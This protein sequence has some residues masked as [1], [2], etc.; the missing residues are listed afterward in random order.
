[1][2]SH[3]MAKFKHFLLCFTLSLLGIL[4]ISTP[5]PG[6]SEDPR[7]LV[8]PDVN[9]IEDYR[10]LPASTALV[11]ALTDAA[12]YVQRWTYSR[13]A[14]TWRERRPQVERALLKAIGLE[15]LPERT[16]LNPRIIAS[17]DLGDYVLENWIFYSR[18][19]LPVTANL[20]RPKGSNAARHPAVVCP[21]G[22]YLDGGKANL[23]YQIL[24][25]K[26]AKLGF[27]VLIYDAIGHGERLISGNTH[28]EAGFALLPLGQT[29]A[30]WMVWESMRA[31]DFLSTLPEV[32][33]SRIGVTGNSGGGLNTL[34]TAALDERVRA[35]AIAGYV[36]HFN[37]WIKYAGSHCTCCYLPGLYRSM[38][39]FEVASLTA[40]RAL[41]MLQGER[42][43][44]FAIVGARKA[45]RE[46]EAV[47]SLLGHKGS[48]RFDE[49]SGQHHAYSQPFRERIYG[50]MLLHLIGQGDG[51][52]TP[53]GSI[54]PLPENDE[55]LLCDKSGTLMANSPSVVALARRQA[56]Q[57]ISD[58]SSAD[59]RTVREA[60]RGFI[61][62]LTQPPDPE[63]HYLMPLSME[64]G[65]SS[66]GIPEKVFFLSEDGQHVPGLLWLPLHHQAPHPTLII[67]NDKGKTAVAES[68]M[69]EPLLDG[70]FAVLSVDLRGRGETLGRS[71][72]RFDNNFHLAAHSVMWGRPIAG[73]R[74]LD[75]KRTVDF[76][77]SRQ[78]LSL[79][80][81]TV[82][83]IGDE[84]LTALLAAADDPRI[85]AVACAGYYNSFLAQIVAAKVTSRA[86]LVRVWNS[87][88]MNW[89]RLDTGNFKAD[90]GSV[91]PSVL[92]TADVP[93]IA[94]LVFPRKLLYCQVRD[95]KGA[96][97]AKYQ[98][99][100][101]QILAST[102]PN[103]HDWASYYPDKSLDAGLLL[104]WLTSP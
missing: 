58:L 34:F 51:K 18:P 36:F 80:D 100:F 29:I 52:P 95:N 1:L 55:R 83:G 47:Y 81:L 99:R 94:S 50:W 27:F 5:A 93:E 57:A 76:V 10:V 48:A 19:D 61:A 49:I 64:K 97:S 75:L 54:Q 71:G 42:D 79:K 87:S 15:K 86:E 43:D 35:A 4:C 102:S 85:K 101:K 17:H 74:A 26:L 91:I 20:Y 32:D 6:A 33:S 44:M 90:L 53:E 12:E 38:E 72:T 63:P 89:G 13:D 16:P 14:N 104:K 66:D 82:V 67:V 98:T 59:L 84:G 41:L 30:G 31:I 77:E 88:A 78:D 28:H 8:T 62:Q 23:E 46:T 39:W 92:L 68:G 21:L 60:A 96:D 9:A 69:V 24:A 3:I 103:G 37:H 70:G 45:G 25:I 65:Q 56:Q 40:P 73:R 7:W 22:H 11:K 2:L